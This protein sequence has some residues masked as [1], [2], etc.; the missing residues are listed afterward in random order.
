MIDYYHAGEYIYEWRR[1]CF[2]TPSATTAKREDVRWLKKEP[3]G[4]TASYIRQ[5]RSGGGG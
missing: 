5:Q 3:R 4:F 1:H 2:P